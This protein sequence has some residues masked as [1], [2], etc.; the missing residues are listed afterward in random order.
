MDPI[1]QY[2]DGQRQV[3]E[4]FAAI[5]AN[6]GMAAPALARFA[7]VRP[8][9]DLLDVGCGTGAFALTA[10]RAGARVTGVDITPKL[11]DRGIE[12]AALAEVEVDWHVGDVED[13]PFEDEAFDIVASQFGH[14]FAPRPDVAVIEMLRV[15][16]PGGTIAFSTWPPD[17]FIGLGFNLSASYG[18]PLPDGI[19]PPIAWGDPEFIDARL[20]DAVTDIEYESAAILVPFLSPRHARLFFEA[21]LGPIAR[22]VKHLEG[23]PGRLAD[24]RRQHEEIISDFFE[25]NLLRQEFLM[26]RAVKK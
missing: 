25:D 22:L 8:G 13:L 15:T 1:S 10:A 3:W 4:G 21:N 2:K 6:T 12:N 26:T 19:T 14:M 23:E 16:R 20:G 9:S 24:Y 18:P 11:I 17:L 5:E 7:G